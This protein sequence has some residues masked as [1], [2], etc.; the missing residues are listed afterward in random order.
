VT[1]EA[2]V[3]ALE[4]LSH[5]GYDVYLYDQIGGGL[6]ARL[7][8]MEDYT[9]SRHVAD[10]EAIRRQ[11]SDSKVILVGKSWGAHLVSRYVAGYPE[12]VARGVLV[13]PGPLYPGEWKD[14]DA[15]SA[16]D[17]LPKEK[18]DAFYR[19]L[20]PRVVTAMLLVWINP[21]AAARF[22]SQAEADAFGAAM[23]SSLIEG[24]VCDPAHVPDDL[25]GELNLWTSL[26]PSDISP[27][28]L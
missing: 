3:K 24:T 19:L 1:S 6:S 9:V 17:R 11:I 22:L 25:R 21:Q 18:R 13:S 5:D 23:M 2:V 10:L 12:N 14:R 15:G 26:W 20:T 7:E 4:P 27:P 16:M 28:S 8:N